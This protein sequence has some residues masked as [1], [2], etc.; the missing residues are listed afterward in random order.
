LSKAFPAKLGNK[1]SVVGQTVFAVCVTNKVIVPHKFHSILDGILSKSY[2]AVKQMLKDRTKSSTKYYKDMPSVVAKSLV[3]KY[4]KNKKCKSVCKMVLPICG[5]KGKQI[6]LDNNSIRIPCITKKESI[7]IHPLKPITGNI[8]S[9]EFW[10]RKSKWHMSYTYNTPVEIVETNGFCGVDRNARDN[11]ATIADPISGKV[12]RLGPDIMLWKNNLKN[13][14]AKLQSRG[15]KNLLVKINRT[16]SN[17]TKDINHKVS[18]QIIDF[19]IL[20][21]KAIALE[22][23]SKI[24]SGKCGKFVKKSNWS[25]F[26]LEQFIKY[27]ASLHGIPVVYINPAYTSKTCSRCGIINNVQGKKFS[28]INCNHKDHRDANAAF[29]IAKFACTDVIDTNERELVSGR[30]D[31]PQTG[32]GEVRC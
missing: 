24:K 21:R 29:N 3:V 13:R 1:D 10:K 27:K 17:R 6:K 2:V 31:A 25:Y 7:P 8:R 16:Q 11:V 22:D 19:A 14:K 15:V 5:D 18:K 28:C 32:K 4:Q 26:Q 20:H 23:L 30:I 12:Q 9:V